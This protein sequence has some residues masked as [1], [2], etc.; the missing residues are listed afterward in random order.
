[1]AD[2]D[3]P[4]ARMLAQRFLSDRHPGCELAVTPLAFEVGHACNEI[5]RLR[6]QLSDE[7][8]SRVLETDTLE[9]RVRYYR[10]EWENAVEREQYALARVAE[11]E[12]ERDEE[13]FTVQYGL[14]QHAI[15]KARAARY[16]EAL[17]W[18][19][20]TQ[21]IDLLDS[22]NTMLLRQALTTHTFVSHIFLKEVETGERA[23]AALA[24][25]EGETT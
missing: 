20:D 2:F 7:D 11:V 12:K 8:K 25:G 21:H 14:K 17:E 24:G 13:R 15:T 5:D 4:A 1:M 16:R 23:R 22:E 3:V 9:E 6:A 19:A 18:Y 10:N